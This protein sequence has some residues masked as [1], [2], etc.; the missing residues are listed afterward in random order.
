M[1]KKNEKGQSMTEYILIIA[2][3]AL[4]VFAAVKLLGGN[5]KKG[6]NEAANKVG[7]ATQTK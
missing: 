7:E 5:V 4:V 1:Y 6:F 3:I 2:L